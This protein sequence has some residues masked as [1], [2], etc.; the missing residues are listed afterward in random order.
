[1]KKVKNYEIV[2]AAEMLSELLGMEF[3]FQREF[4][5]LERQRTLEEEEEE[6]GVYDLMLM[7]GNTLSAIEA[8][9]E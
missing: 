2:K 1:M 9:E 8:R 6:I 7:I 3:N 5:S 4:E